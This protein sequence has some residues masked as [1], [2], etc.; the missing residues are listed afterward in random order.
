MISS[1]SLFWSVIALTPIVLLELPQPIE[2]FTSCLIMIPLLYLS[3]LIFHGEIIA[4][5]KPQNLQNSTVMPQ[6]EGST[7]NSSTEHNGGLEIP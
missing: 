4:K 6:E 5:N 7:Y 3:A 1:A 2:I